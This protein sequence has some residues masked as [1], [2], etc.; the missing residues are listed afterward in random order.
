MLQ[1]SPEYMPKYSEFLRAVQGGT[2]S[3]A[4]LEKVYG[5]P[6]RRHRKRPAGV[7]SGQPVLCTPFPGEARR[8]QGEVPRDARSHVRCKT[9]AG[10][11]DQPAR[12]GSRDPPDARRPRARG[13]Q[14]A[15]AMG[16]PGLSGM[17]PQPESPKPST[18]SG[19]PT[20]WAIAVPQ[21]S[22]GFRTSG[23]AGASGEAVDA[24]TDL[25]Q[26]GA[27]T[28]G[29]SHGA[30]RF[31][32]ERP[33]SRRSTYGSRGAHS[34]HGGRR[35]SFLHAA[36][37]CADPARRP[38]RSSHHRGETGRQRQDT[39][40]S[41]AGRADAALSRSVRRPTPPSRPSLR[42]AH[43]SRTSRRVW[44]VRRPTAQSGPVPPPAPEVEGSFVEFVCLEKTA[45][46]WSSIPQRARKDS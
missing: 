9:R 18:H 16:R 13:S 22:V 12:Q 35:A 31:A 28:A 20:I 10:G 27:R 14:A 4:A 34:G 32:S 26:S 40:G 36:G 1:L 24:L 29:R 37:Q 41:L 19:K 21:T 11:P 3:A 8:C 30:R 7:Y 17:A 23:R 5:K 43:R 39:R 33:A 6:V 15:R 42:R 46:R 38:R 2:D 25:F 44:C 45:S